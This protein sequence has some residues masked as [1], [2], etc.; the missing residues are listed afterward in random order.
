MRKLLAAAVLSL[1]T[2]TV[3]PVPVYAQ[4]PAPATQP[5]TQIPVKSVVLFSSGVGYFEHRGLVHAD[6]A[7]ELHFKTEQINDI[8]K[9][10]VLKDLD[11]GNIS[12]VS[13]P[14]Q[15]PVEK[16]L[17]SF[18]VDLTSNPSLAELLN[19]LRG[20]RV[21][22]QTT[23][24][25][26]G[27]ILGVEKQ[28]RPV[29]DKATIEKSVLNLVTDT[30][31]RAIEMDDVRSFHFEDAGLQKELTRALAV[32]A[33]GRDKDKKPITLHFA[34]NGDRHVRVG[35]VVETPVWKVSYRLILGDKPG[36]QGYAIIDNQTDSDWTDISL[37][38]ISGRPISFVQDLYSPLYLTRPVVGPDV[39]GTVAPQ[40]YA[41]GLAIAGTRMPMG[42]AGKV[43]EDRRMFQRLQGARD[44]SYANQGQ[45]A[46]QNAAANLAG[47]GVVDKQYFDASN[48]ASVPTEKVGE[49][50]QYTVGNVNVPRQTSAM[51]PIIGDEIQAQ[52]VSIYNASVLPKNPLNGVRLK[53]TTGKNLMA[54]PVTV[55][56]GDVYAGDARIDSTVPDQHRLLSYGVDQQMLVNSDHNTNQQTII[57]GK[58]VKGVMQLQRKTIAT[59]DYVADNK[60]DKD[61]TLIIEH[62]IKQGWHL[63]DTDKPLETTDTL[64]RFKEIVPAKKSA[65]MTVKEEVTQGE[66][67]AILPLDASAL[68][69]YVN[70]GEIDK[71]LR[72]AL[73]QAANMK[74]AMTDT[75]RQ[76]AE[77]KQHIADYATEQNRIRE[78]L[79]SVNQNSQYYNRLITKLNDQE[80]AIEKLQMEMDD[81]QKQLDK[82]RGDYEGYVNGLTLG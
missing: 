6:S 74:Q 59:Q 44:Q 3:A 38:L 18:Q 42:A 29:G 5:V 36:I 71:S 57:A 64:Y 58:I 46:Q 7:A 61:K 52:K 22:I 80:T 60:A 41:E 37:S 56:D 16:T 82:Q 28:Q 20:A 51:I 17:K 32:V 13:Y 34:G 81:L 2:L 66:A 12:V 27:T 21:S 53:N 45:P 62:P 63:L 24:S 50:F 49:L 48:A 79:R 26:S 65:K 68:M 1:A 4:E 39:Y 25:F 8:L 54:G 30:G 11:G 72:D 10:L 47:G 73:A 75:E 77:H 19:Q 78:N 69:V 35:Y 43:I 40:Q 31:I 70:N 55:L 15:D 76:V 9:S 14:S 33:S 23:D 67:I